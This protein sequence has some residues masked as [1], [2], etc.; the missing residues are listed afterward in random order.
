LG[1]TGVARVA[2]SADATEDSGD[3]AA[4]RDWW[5]FE[6]TVAGGVPAA[7]DR[8]RAAQLFATRVSAIEVEH[9]ATW[10]QLSSAGDSLVHDG[11]QLPWA[12]VAWLVADVPRQLAPEAMVLITQ[13]RPEDYWYVLPL[14]SAL[15]LLGLLFIWALVRSLRAARAAAR[16]AA[17]SDP[18]PAEQALAA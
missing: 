1:F 15:G 3:Q 17:D 7:E 14:F 5:T 18:P 6:V 9:R 8:L 11:Q 2:D 10:G 4:A 13:D 12:T 16:E